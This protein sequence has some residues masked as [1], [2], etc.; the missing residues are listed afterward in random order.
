MTETDIKVEKDLNIGIKE[1]NSTLQ[2]TLIDKSEAIT[3]ITP[4]NLSKAEAYKEDGNKAFKGYTSKNK[5]KRFFFTQ[6]LKK[7]SIHL[8]QNYAK[9]IEFYTLA[10]EFNPKEASYYGNR[11]FASIKSEFYGKK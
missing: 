6:N 8:E 11:S 2:N 10:I 1:I 3:E 7:Y 4:E 9:A 5:N